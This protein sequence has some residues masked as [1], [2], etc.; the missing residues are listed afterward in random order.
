LRTPILASEKGGAGFQRDEKKQ[1]R[2]TSPPIELERP[3]NVGRRH[4]VPTA[5]HIG[6]IDHLAVIVA[7]ASELKA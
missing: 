6:I 3:A 1:S 2:S 7:R 4:Y 5:T